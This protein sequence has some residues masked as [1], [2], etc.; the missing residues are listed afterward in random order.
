M[1]PNF[2]SLSTDDKYR[3]KYWIVFGYRADLKCHGYFDHISFSSYQTR[4]C[5]Y[6]AKIQLFFFGQ[7]AKI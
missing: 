1:V 6:S 7:L 3:C 5:G 2:K 4:A